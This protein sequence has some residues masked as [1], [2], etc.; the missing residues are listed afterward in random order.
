[1]RLNPVPSRLDD[2]DQNPRRAARSS[3]TSVIRILRPAATAD[4]ISAQVFDDAFAQNLGP[5]LAVECVD[6]KN[7]LDSI[8][9]GGELQP[10][11][12]SVHRAFASATRNFDFL[13]PNYKVIPFVPLLLYIRNRS[14]API[15]LLLIAHAPGA[16]VLEWS[17]LR[18]LLRTGDLVITPTDSARKVI[19]FLC[20]ELTPYTRVVPHPM[21]PLRH[22]RRVRPR[23]IVS[24][25]RMHSSKLLHR[26]IEALAVLR[27]RGVSGLSMR[28]A[29]PLHRPG[30][31]DLI[32]YARSLA[33]KIK[34]LHL[35]DSVELTG[36]ISGVEQKAKF[37]SEARLLINLSVTIEESFGKSILEAVGCGVPVLATCWNGFPETV[38]DA[39]TL[40]PADFTELGVDVSAECIA[41]GL[42]SLLDAPP[43]RDT[44][45][46]QAARFHPRRVRRL[47][48]QALEE[49]MEGSRATAFSDD[50]PSLDEPA[51]ALS[52]LLSATAPLTRFSWN[53]LFSLHLQDATRWRAA[54]AGYPSPGLSEIDELRDLL[55]AGVQ[56]PLERL[57]AGAKF[58][59]TSETSDSSFET[60][61]GDFIG[62]VSAA[63]QSHA[64]TSSRLACLNFLARV[65]RFEALESGLETMRAS[66]SAGPSL[67]YLE[68]EALR[69]SGEY[70]RAFM[71]CIE[72]EEEILWSEQAAHLLRQ[73]AAICREW[74]L[75]GFAL[76]WLRDWLERFP[77]SPESG[78]VWLDRA[79]NALALAPALLEEA[80]QA[81]ETARALLGE[82]VD[83][84]DLATSISRAEDEYAQSEEMS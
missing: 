17:L 42:Q 31:T 21:R 24:L 8:F 84:S 23:H 2:V 38:G 66:H 30:S 81:F 14:H 50:A 41:D 16:Y 22:A 83:L 37:L 53:D 52:G 3:L 64:T 80:R 10:D 51:A 47:Y 32:P 7:W 46:H 44:C 57:L 60:G 13:C 72:S 75:P 45:K 5:E 11:E 65:E 25:T 19:D 49:S 61:I 67:R 70:R 69:L 62:R 56:A 27:D 40:V 73:L 28:I 26:Q 20:P 59:A 74:K 43:S 68:T 71:M 39:G 54:L 33:A 6:P 63:A 1:M 55:I 18:P 77:D 29:S 58:N 4:L 15:R 76:P 48:R 36:P 34:R 78:M 12:M 82:S 79:V 35:G 9:G